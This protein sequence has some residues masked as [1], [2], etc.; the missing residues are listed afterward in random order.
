MGDGVCCVKRSVGVLYL[1]SP[2]LVYPNLHPNPPEK[3][4]NRTEGVDSRF[5]LNKKLS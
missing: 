2:L 1:L 4:A 5:D 3:N